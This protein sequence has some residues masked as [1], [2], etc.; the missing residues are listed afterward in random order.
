MEENVLSQEQDE[1]FVDSNNEEEGLFDDYVA[2]DTPVEETIGENPEPAQT[3]EEA[4][5]TEV[6]NEPFLTIQYDKQEYGLTH[7]EAKEL[8]EKGKNYDRMRD[9]YNNLY[10]SLDR[11][12]KLNEMDV[13][14]Y[15]DRL[16]STQTDY[17][18]NKEFNRLKQ[19]HPEDNEDLLKEIA[20]RRVQENL[21]LRQKSYNEE[22]TR[23]ADAQSEQARREVDK[24]LEEYPEFKNQ[25]PS[26]VIN[27]EIE[28]YMR[29]GFTLLEAYNKWAKMQEMSKKPLEDAK[30]KTSQ[31]NEEN[32]RR[33]LGNTS[34]AGKT[35]AD[36]FLIG[37]DS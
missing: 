33:S 22:Q 2:D 34:N 1:L 32:K 27:S 7:D 4:P 10:D 11:L 21:D 20:Q 28:G 29:N 35:E 17:M 36:P 26:T 12:A 9:K 15:I 23:V 16:N 19:E 3:E 8:A 25:D 6:S 5:E 37:L 13:E 31:L 30:Q 14:Q 24:F 18:V